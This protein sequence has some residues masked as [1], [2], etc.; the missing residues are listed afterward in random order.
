VGL[1][2]MYPS[3]GCVQCGPR[4]RDPIVCGSDTGLWPDS[5]RGVESLAEGNSGSADLWGRD[6]AGQMFFY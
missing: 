6:L 2:G 5:A 3:G 1:G 4:D